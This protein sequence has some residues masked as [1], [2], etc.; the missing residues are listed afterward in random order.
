MTKNA[1]PKRVY[2]VVSLFLAIKKKMDDSNYLIPAKKHIFDQSPLV[3]FIVTSDK[4]GACIPVK[5]SIASF[6]GGPSSKDEDG[7]DLAQLYYQINSKFPVSRIIWIALPTFQISGNLGPKTVRS[8]DVNTKAVRALSYDEYPAVPTWSQ[9]VQ[10][11]PT[12]FVTTETEINKA[13]PASSGGI[14]TPGTLYALVPGSETVC[15]VWRN[16]SDLC[17][18][19]SV[20]KP[21]MPTLATLSAIAKATHD[22][23]QELT[24]GHGLD[25][26]RNPHKRT[27]FISDK[28]LPATLEKIYGYDQGYLFV[29]GHP[30]YP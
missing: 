14:V 16:I 8:I 29:P 24:K 7:E 10:S 12:F 21:T 20:Q 1:L 6:L 25:K 19:Q 22:I 9:Y 17:S 13:P 3:I 15:N 11:F 23:F 28:N 2:I 18:Y 4:C 26:L 5:K 27:G 30:Y